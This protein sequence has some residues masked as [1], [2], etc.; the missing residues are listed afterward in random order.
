MPR[1]TDTSLELADGKPAALAGLPVSGRITGTFGKSEGFWANRTPHSG[2]DIA[3]PEGTPI[4]APA[5][6]VAQP[7]DFNPAFGLW[8]RLQHADDTFTA[9]AHMSRQAGLRWGQHVVQGQVIGYVGSTGDSTGAH[10]HWGFSVDGRFPKWT[11]DGPL[12]D[13][14]DYLTPEAVKGEDA[15]PETA[16]ARIGQLEERVLRLERR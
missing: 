14:F 8:V 16:E 5:A 2:V 9:Y 11:E 6:G 10:L 7:F 12:R 1:F 3:A 13:P 15:K 4:R